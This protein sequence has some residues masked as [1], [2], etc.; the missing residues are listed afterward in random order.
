MMALAGEDC[1][2]YRRLS[3]SRSL[4]A[5]KRSKTWDLILDL[6]PTEL[7]VGLYVKIACLSHTLSPNTRHFEFCD[8]TGDE[9][10]RKER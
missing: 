3:L 2:V 5:T 10:A 6:R 9:V 1:E 7:E 4:K 8:D